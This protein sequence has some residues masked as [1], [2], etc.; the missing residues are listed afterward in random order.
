MKSYYPHVDGLR[1]ISIV[2]VLIFHAFPTLL[3]GGSLGVDIFFVISGFVV[4]RSILFNKNINSG[5]LFENATYFYSRRVKRILP[6]L[7]L[8]LLIVSFIFVF[9]LDTAAVD[10]AGKK[11][12]KTAAFASLGT[13]NIFLYFSSQ[14]YYATSTQ[15]NPFTHTWSLGIEEQFYLIFPFIIFLF[16]SNL[17]KV[18]AV[19]SVLS[20]FA[21]VLLFGNFHAAAF[22][23]L[24][25][26]FWEL[27]LGA[28]LAI[29]R[30]R[31]LQFKSLRHSWIA[32]ASLVALGITINF[33]ALT[34]PLPTIIAVLSASGLIIFA[35]HGVLGRLL[36]SK[37][38]IHIGL[39]SYSLYL[40]HW[41]I[42]V[43]GRWTIGS[44]IQATLLCLFAAIL[45]SELAYQALETPLRK[46]RWF[47]SP[48]KTA[49]VGIALMAATFQ[50]AG[51]QAYVLAKRN[52][53]NLV[54][55]LGAPDLEQD[56]PILCHEQAATSKYSDPIEACL[57]SDRSDEKPNILFTL[58]DSHAAHMTY[59]LSEASHTTPYQVRFI[60]TANQLDPP[61]CFF[62][63]NACKDSLVYQATLE[64]VKENDLVFFT[65]L[66]SHL[67]EKYLSNIPLNEEVKPN[68]KEKNLI[69][70][71][72]T[73]AQE[74][75][76]RKA[77]LV[78]AL[79]V[80]LL[81]SER[82]SIVSCVIQQRLFDADDCQVD[83]DQTVHTRT[84]QERAFMKVM[85]LNG[86]VDVW[87]AAK[88]VFED[89][90]IVS[91][92]DAE[93]RYRFIDSNHITQHQSL[94]LTDDFKKQ[95][96]DSLDQNR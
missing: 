44:S 38:A 24:P 49:L 66:S 23:L 73:F 25:T 17:A 48:K 46:Y 62:S 45:L 31:L 37:T 26:R 30:E 79:D 29:H 82:R 74:L 77:N 57:S 64:K 7:L 13:S 76:K 33:S 11:I 59:M 4:T 92:L 78:L 21:Y 65:F 27:G 22:Y 52:T 42:L 60:N 9:V 6:A 20:L 85:E 69:S 93:G 41:P 91:A 50:V 86:N 90:N 53:T 89:D 15:L 43:L 40:W 87:D 80:P 75:K 34:S 84:R 3:P 83:I 61:Y 70:A 67:N 72:N 32:L 16:R 96:L 47:T 18:I 88:A 1:A 81:N 14:G 39:R 95:I 71:L 55:I 10:T 12:F 68:Q 8:M 28:L 56:D 51:T 58:G 2:L 36:G 5:S 63:D 54:Y 19:A 94:K 35:D